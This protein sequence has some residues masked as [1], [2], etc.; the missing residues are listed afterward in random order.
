MDWIQLQKEFEQ[1]TPFDITTSQGYPHLPLHRLFSLMVSSLVKSAKDVRRIFE[2]IDPQWNPNSLD[3]IIHP[4]RLQVF[5]S[6]MRREKSRTHVYAW[7]FIDLDIYPLQLCL[8]T[9][10]P[11]VFVRELISTSV[12][13]N[14][15]D[16]QRSSSMRITTTEMQGLDDCLTLLLQVILERARSGYDNRGTLFFH[17]IRHCI[18]MGLILPC[19]HPHPTALLLQP[20]EEQQIPLHSFSCSSLLLR[21][22]H[23][24]KENGN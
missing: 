3:I 10:S 8:A 18:L 19:G 20:R 11:E 23:R 6:K 16:P 12:L 4:L 5:I 14:L 17:F 1:E 24:S 15:L 13:T 21:W 2:E 22:N 9:C 7:L